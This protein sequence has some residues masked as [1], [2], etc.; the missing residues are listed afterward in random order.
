MASI[1]IIAVSEGKE[2]WLRAALEVYESK[3]KH[4]C[5]FEIVHVKPYKE[6]RAAVQEKVKKESA[7]VLSKLTDKDHVIL[8]EVKGKAFTSEGFAQQLEKNL[9]N[10]PNKTLTFIIGGAYGAGEELLSRAQ[11]KLKLS[12]MTMNHY[13]AEVVLLEQI[14]RAYTI[15]KGIPYHN[16]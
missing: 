10:Y 11:E 8:C 12:E 9:T 14:Y 1:K 15:I 5:K 6:A 16:A 3:L 7:A 2:E 4:F 13:V